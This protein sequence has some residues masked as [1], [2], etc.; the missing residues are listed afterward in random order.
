ME[1]TATMKLLK[2]QL[3]SLKDTSDDLDSY[4]MEL[5]SNIEWIL[6]DYKTMLDKPNW[7]WIKINKDIAIWLL[8]REKEQWCILPFVV[9]CYEYWKDTGD[10]CESCCRQEC[11][12]WTEVDT[13]DIETLQEDNDNY[14]ENF[15]LRF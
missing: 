8:K 9:M 4:Q 14:Y 6:H 7:W 13:D 5:I 2:P 1:F 10:I 3:D 15:E 12:C 11:L